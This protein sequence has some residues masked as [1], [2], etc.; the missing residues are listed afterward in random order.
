MKIQTIKNQSESSKVL[1]Y[2]CAE[3]DT[4]VFTLSFSSIK[5]LWVP[6]KQKKWCL[7]EMIHGSLTHGKPPQ[8]NLWDKIQL[9]KHQGLSQ[10]VITDDRLSHSDYLCQ[11][12]GEFN[13]WKFLYP[14][15][16]GNLQSWK[17]LFIITLST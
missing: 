14:A 4:N 1:Y 7:T 10:N 15:L 12:L 11:F 9:T 3:K 17:N 2:C 5:K 6:V 13:V 16:S 8:N